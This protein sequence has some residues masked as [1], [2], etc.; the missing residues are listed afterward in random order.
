MLIKCWSH[1]LK[2]S[3]NLENLG[4]D[5]RITSI[6]TLRETDVDNVGWIHMCANGE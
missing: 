6:F 5:G 1:N 4:V 3:D 2:K